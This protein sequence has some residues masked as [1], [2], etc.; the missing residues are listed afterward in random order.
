M[1]L[2]FHGNSSFYIINNNNL[3]R[4]ASKQYHFIVQ[5]YWHGVHY[6]MNQLCGSSFLHWLIQTLLFMKA[7]KHWISLCWFRLSIFSCLKKRSKRILWL[8]EQNLVLYKLHRDGKSWGD[9]SLFL[10]Q[11]LLQSIQ[12][13]AKTL[14]TKVINPTRKKTQTHKQISNPIFSQNC[15]CPA[16]LL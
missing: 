7:F 14:M 2:E 12:K 6:L 9:H 1:Q 11:Q 8:H 5:V 4:I 16:G 10:V 13:K 15:Y 3:F